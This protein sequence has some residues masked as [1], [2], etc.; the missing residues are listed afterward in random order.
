MFND[1]NIRMISGLDKCFF[2]VVVLLLLW[3]SSMISAQQDSLSM[4]KKKRKISFRDPEDN[5]FDMSSFLL[6]HKGLL[7][8]PVL[9][10][11]PALGYGGGAALIYFHQRK[12]QYNT[13]VPPDITGVL[14]LGTQNKT[15]GAGAFHMHTFGK[16]RVRTVTAFVKPNINIDY[17]GNNSELLSKHPI[18]IKLKSWVFFQRAQVRL[19]ESNFY[20]G[21]SYTYFKSN[22][23]LDTIP[24]NTIINEIIKRLNVNSTIGALEPMVVYDNRDN[25]FT[26]TKGINAALAFNFSAQWL[27]SSDD[28]GS[29]N[30]DFFGYLPIGSRLFSAYRFQGSYLIG[31]A[32]FYAYPFVSLRGIPAM[33]YQSDNTLV[34]E[35][36]WRYKIYKRW[37]LTA[38]TGAGKAFQSISNFNDIDWAYTVGAGFR[39]EIARLLGTH[40]GLDFAWGNAKDFAFY[41]VFGTSWL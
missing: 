25:V 15:W 11:E 5:A 18:T 27:G 38:F 23:T 35:T 37:S 3:P 39:Y 21:A 31:E 32:P 2:V 40:M 16:N 30:S 10:T 28:Y 7:P 20:L 19:A 6:E 1:F 36:E 9:I 26:P 12:K 8:V 14:G 33:R 17:Y 34:A 13:N 4:E 29:V 24:G 22:I 41:I